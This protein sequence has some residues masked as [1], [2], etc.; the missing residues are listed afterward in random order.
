MKISGK[1]VLE[2]SSQSWNLR[3]ITQTQTPDLIREDRFLSAQFRLAAIILFPEVHVDI[4]K[5]T[6]LIG[7]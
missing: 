4:R 6:K 5:S 2:Y 3:I 1:P 7:L